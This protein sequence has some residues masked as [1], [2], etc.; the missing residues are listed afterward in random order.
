MRWEEVSP[1]VTT[2]ASPVNPAKQYYEFNILSA[3]SIDFGIRLSTMSMITMHKV[4]SYG[5]V[6]LNLNLK[7]KELDIQFPLKTGNQM[8]NFRFRLPISLLSHI[9]KVSDTETGQIILIIPCDSPPQF[10][11]QKI[12]D[13]KRSNGGNR[14][15][16]SSK[17]K[18]WNEWDTWYRET[19]VIDD[20]A[21]ELLKELPLM[22]HKDKAIIDIGKC[23]IVAKNYC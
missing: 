22:N 14:T 20:V 16:F 4:E 9:Y 13:E 10:F 15:S 7:R 19:D 1:H 5:R 8:R 11:V 2:I 18:I 12:E 17:E 6:Q 3:N 21:R 23:K